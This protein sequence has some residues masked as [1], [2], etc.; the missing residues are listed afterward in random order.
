MATISGTENDDVLNG[1]KADDTLNG[2]SGDDILNGGAGS[3]TLIGGEGN[4]ALHGGA[5]D[6]NI[7]GGDGDDTL[8]GGGGNDDLTGG[9]GDDI[10]NGGG[11]NDTFHFKFTFD[12]GETTTLTFSSVEDGTTQNVSVQEYKEW[13]QSSG[14][15]LN[16]DGVVD[17][18]Y[19]QNDAEDPLT[20]L[21]GAIVDGDVTAVEITTGKTSQERYY[22]FQIE[23]PGEDQLTS[24]DGHDMIIGFNWDQDKLNFEGLEAL[25]KEE[26]SEWFDVTD[27]QD[28]N[29][30][31]VNDTVVSISGS[32]D[33][34]LTLLGV[35]GHDEAAFYDK[36]LSDNMVA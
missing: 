22:E 1:T 21:E 19:N 25:S 24:A 35:S 26:F 34:S 9:S 33:W 27:D 8:V 17:Y 4:D 2:G 28:V 3:D 36:A 30:D 7:L 31:G 29:G 15:D 18:T 16:G 32:E 14:Q 5:G 23:I 10:L 12:K 20:S 6:D 11:G 13:L